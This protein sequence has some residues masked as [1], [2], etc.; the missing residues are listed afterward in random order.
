M[1]DVLKKAL[2]MDDPESLFK[3][4]PESVVPKEESSPF[5]DKDDDIPGPNILPQ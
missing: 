3:L 2:V 4:P 5:A 1:D